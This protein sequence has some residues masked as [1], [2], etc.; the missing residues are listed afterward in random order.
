LIDF[1]DHNDFD[2]VARVVENNNDAA[3]ADAADNNIV[4]VSCWEKMDNRFGVEVD[5]SSLF[6]F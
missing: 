6:S 3:A 5:S 2:E 1:D 4:V